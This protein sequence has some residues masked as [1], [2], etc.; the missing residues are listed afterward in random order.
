MAR[1][2]K[3]PLRT[4]AVGTLSSPLP[5]SAVVVAFP[6]REEEQLVLHDRPAERAAE[7]VVDALRR[8]GTGGRIRD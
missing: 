5:R 7:L 4:W 2:L 6:G 3:S 1:P 8:I